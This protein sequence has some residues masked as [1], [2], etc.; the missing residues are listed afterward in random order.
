MRSAPTRGFADGE[1][2]RT[3]NYLQVTE[4]TLDSARVEATA[5]SSTGGRI[6][7]RP[8][9]IVYLCN[10]QRPITTEAAAHTPMED[11]DFYGDHAEPLTPTHDE[12]TTTL[13]RYNGHART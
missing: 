6:K 1:C 8:P 5:D 3:C 4:S 12:G 10:D 11:Q 2:I 7:T 9:W 13:H